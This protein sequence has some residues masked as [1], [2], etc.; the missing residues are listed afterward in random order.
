MV[1]S[2]AFGS[3]FGAYSILSG[4]A[5]ENNGTNTGAPNRDFFGNTR[6]LTT[7]NR[8]DIGAVELVPAAIA[9]PTVTPAPLTF[10]NVVIATT[11]TR[12]LTLANTGGA[13]FTISAINVTGTGF[14]RIT[15]GTFP[16]AA[17]SCGASLAAAASCTIRVQFAPAATGAATGSVTITGNVP[18]N[19]APVA[20]SGTGVVPVVSASLAPPTWSA[21]NTIRGVNALL[22]PTQV[23]TLTNTGNVPLTGIAQGALG[24]TDAAQFA[25]VRA[26]STCGPAG[27]G[28]LAGLT[29]L[30]PNATCVVTVQFRPG[31]A[32][33]LGAKSASIS[34]TDAAGA[35]SSTM[36]GNV[37]G[38]T[39]TFSAPAPSLVTGTTTNHSGTITVSNTAAGANAGPFT[40]TAAPSVAKVGAAGGT[41]SIIGG[42][43]CTLLSVINPGGTCTINVQYAPGATGTTLATA[44]VTATGS[45][46]ATTS[47][48]SANFTAN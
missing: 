46:L 43:T 2:S 27:G 48:T 44:N 15:V 9:I 33:T 30:A 5:A 13:T 37:T 10:G 41:F 22:A 28:Q 4:S 12:D 1:A 23:F 6:A 26:L 16:L 31:N 47:Q 19:N 7:A 18:V 38:A 14:S 45:G 8:A 25:V 21:G 36:T 39:L 35:Q 32:A 40:F 17:P 3:A 29:T 42:G 24:G 11:T 20:L 34:V